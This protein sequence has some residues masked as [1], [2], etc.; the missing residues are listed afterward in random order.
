MYHNTFIHSFVDGH[1]GCSHVLAI[2]NTAAVNVGIHMSFSIMVFSG[3]MPNSGIVGSYGSFI[4]SFL[5][6]LH[7]VLHSG[8]INLHS[9]Q[10]CKEIPISSHFPHL[11]TLSPAFIVCRFFDDG[12]LSNMRWYLII[13]L[14]CISLISNIDHLFNVFITH[15]FVFLREV[16]V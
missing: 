16:S 3:Y 4:S 13:V 2:I 15:L 12:Y 9:H 8:C 11:F 5:M 1:L 14:I 7:T 10:Q 6:N